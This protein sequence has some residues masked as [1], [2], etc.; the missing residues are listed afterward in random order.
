MCLLTKA[1]P[2]SSPCEATIVEVHQGTGSDDLPTPH[3]GSGEIN[4][5][6]I[7]PETKWVNHPELDIELYLST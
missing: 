1:S 6:G 3:D 7:K 5:H 4:K 2:A